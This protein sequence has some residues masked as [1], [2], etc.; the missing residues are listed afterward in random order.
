MSDLLELASKR[1]PPN[2]LRWDKIQKRFPGMSRTA[3]R[4]KLSRLG[5]S[6]PQLPWDPAEDRIL[7]LGWGELSPRVLK[8]KLKRRSRVAIHLRAMVHG[9]SSGPP[10]GFVTIKFL[11]LDPSWGFG[12]CETLRMVQWAEKILNRSFIQ[13]FNY[14]SRIPGRPGVPC[15]SLDEIREAK[16]A[17]MWT[18]SETPPD[19]SKRLGVAVQRIRTWL[20]YEGETTPPSDRDHRQV[21]RGLPGFYDDL[22]GKYMTSSRRFIPHPPSDLESTAVGP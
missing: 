17:G 14:S 20:I 1:R 4:I 22:Y 11:S 19:A 7:L 8:K 9:L 16:V 12:Y 5:Y 13:H 15:V 18:K 10:Q 6:Q 21:Y 3:I 2:R